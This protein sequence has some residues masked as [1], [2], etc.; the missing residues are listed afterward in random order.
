MMG[1]S[2]KYSLT[3]LSTAL[4]GFVSCF[5]ALLSFEVIDALSAAACELDATTTV[6][7]AGSSTGV[8]VAIIPETSIAIPMVSCKISRF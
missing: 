4:L 2:L 5:G 7:L 3:V 6:G 8:D 1:T